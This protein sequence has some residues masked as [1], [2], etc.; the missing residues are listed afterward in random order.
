[1]A[2]EAEAAPLRVLEAR[3]PDI[4]EKCR[5]YTTAREVMAAGLYPYFHV[6][7]SEQC[8]E[9]IVEGRKMIMLGSN[10]KYPPAE[11]GALRLLAPQRGLIAIG[12]SKSKP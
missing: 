10:S 11:P 4:F 8:P 9:V 5:K 3:T 2:I 12:K 6:V 1:M 7:E